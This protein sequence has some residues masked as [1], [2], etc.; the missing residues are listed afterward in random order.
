M[1]LEW[2]GALDDMVDAPDGLVCLLDDVVSEEPR[3]DDE[4]SVSSTCVSL[5]RSASWCG[6]WMT[7][8]AISTAKRASSPW[9]TSSSSKEAALKDVG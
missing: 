9:S 5:L 8:V 7:D 6:S 4:K 1:G 3:G 2:E